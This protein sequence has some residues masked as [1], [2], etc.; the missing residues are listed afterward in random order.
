MWCKIWNS[1]WK[2]E[3]I[4]WVISSCGVDERQATFGTDIMGSMERISEL[5]TFLI[6]SLSYVIKI[7]CLIHKINCENVDACLLDAL[8][9]HNIGWQDR[10]RMEF[11]Q[12][13]MG[14]GECFSRIKQPRFAQEG[15]HCCVWSLPQ[16]PGILRFTVAASLHCFCYLDFFYGHN[17][18]LLPGKTGSQEDFTSAASWKRDTPGV[19]LWSFDIHAWLNINISTRINHGV[20]MPIMRNI[21][22]MMLC[23]DTQITKIMLCDW[24]VHEI[25]NVIGCSI[26]VDHRGHMNS[27]ICIDLYASKGSWN[28]G[29]LVNRPLMGRN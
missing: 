6:D 8:F 9:D 18:A 28:T 24:R 22:L 29:R 19:N 16:Q 3:D 21:A 26:F 27:T 12:Y 2:F 15:W 23:K 25:L 10:V 14:H 13:S 20:L 4:L 5:S 7:A 17:L 1:I 11:C